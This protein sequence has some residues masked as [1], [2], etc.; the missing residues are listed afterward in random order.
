MPP[1]TATHVLPV[2][3]DS[4][5]GR[6]EE[7][8]VV[9]RLLQSSARVVTLTGSAG[10]GKSSVAIAAA[11][12]MQRSVP[13]LW[14]VDLRD[15]GADVATS[16]AHELKADTGDDATAAIIAA[17]S[18]E[19]VLLVLDNADDAV[20]ET[21]AVVDALLVSCPGVRLIVTSRE[22]LGS[23]GEALVAIG[24]FAHLGLSASS[25]AVRLFAERAAWGDAFFRVDDTT[26]PTVL[27]ICERTHGVP[28]AL[29]LAA[30]QL[31]FMDLDTLGAR[32]TEQLD[33]LEPAERTTRSLRDAV[34]DSWDRCLPAERR[35]WSDLTVLAPGW[36][37]QLGE[38]MAGL[39][40]SGPR[41]ATLVV[42][43][44]VRRSVIHRRRTDD[45]VRYE[46]LPAIQEF[47]AARAENRDAARVRFLESMLARLHDAED[48]WFS[49]AQPEILRRL[50]GDIPN[51][52][53]AVATA[54]ALG[55]PDTA[56]ELTTTACRQAW[57]IHG[58]ADELGSWLD[59]A[60]AAGRPSPRWESL[61]HALRSL[62]SM[63]TGRPQ[64]TDADYRLALAA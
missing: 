12:G 37:L 25:D 23:P 35:V 2:R 53:H 50:R 40:V 43:Q 38:A 15:R 22:P 21:A 8:S 59:T 33:A 27:R 49:P 31:Q 34:E 47:G 55:R 14:Y 26:L 10:V 4:M 45:G 42:K 3:F 54:A 61:G 57:L 64:G 13:G 9:R 11:G 39:S 41:E 20:A 29:E 48:H 1:S 51:I 36:D 19:D 60:L 62:V 52:R 30:A 17:I 56:V 44:L 6:R 5:L 28:L 7:V 18:D 16:I 58:S 24:P 46:L 63:L 32:I